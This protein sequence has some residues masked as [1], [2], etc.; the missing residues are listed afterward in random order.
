MK[1]ALSSDNRAHRLR[2]AVE[3]RSVAGWVPELVGV[4]RGLEEESWEAGTR[5]FYEWVGG[6]PHPRMS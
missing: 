3:A 5:D 4:R 2:A 6:L 1:G